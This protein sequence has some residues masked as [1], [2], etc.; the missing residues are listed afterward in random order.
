MSEKHKSNKTAYK[1]WKNFSKS[2]NRIDNDAA[3]QLRRA[4]KQWKMDG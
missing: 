4:W 2:R 1:K 3:T